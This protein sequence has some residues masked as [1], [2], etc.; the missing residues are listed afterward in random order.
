MGFVRD[1]GLD[2]AKIKRMKMIKAIQL[3]QK[4]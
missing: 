3:R 2:F 4:C 1:K